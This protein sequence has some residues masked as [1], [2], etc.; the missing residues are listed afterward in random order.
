MIVAT[1]DTHAIIWYLYN[2]KRL[3]DTVKRFVRAT[4]ENG[5]QIGI[6]TIALVEIV[7]LS[8]KGRIPAQAPLIV[9]NALRES[10][11]VWAEIPLFFP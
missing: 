3:P 1:A 10:Q 6:A 8:E 11:S 4:S 5:H 9:I 2:D 7:Y